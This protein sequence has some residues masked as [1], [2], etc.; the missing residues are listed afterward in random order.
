M[1]NCDAALDKEVEVSFGPFMSN[2]GRQETTVSLQRG[3][4]L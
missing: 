2:E 4:L 1:Q 3:R